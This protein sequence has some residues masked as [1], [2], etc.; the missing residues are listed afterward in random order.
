MI[1]FDLETTNHSFGSALDKRNRIVMVSWSESGGPI[2][3]YTGDIMEASEFWRALARNPN[4]CAFNA[5]FE[6]HWLKRCGYDVDA[7]RWHDP[8]LAEKVLLGNIKLP[9]NLGDTCERYNLDTKDTMIDSMMKSGVCPSDM[10]QKRLASRCNRDVRT[11]RNLLRLQMG[12]LQAN[13][14][15]HLYRNRCDFSVVLTHIEA[16][17]M[18]LS[19]ERVNDH[20]V[21]YAHQCALL[22]KQ[23]DELTGGLNMNSPKQKAEYIYDTLKFKER[24][25][26]NR[27][28]LRTAKG[29]RKTDAD[30]LTWL[31]SQAR[32]EAQKLFV[33][34]SKEYSKANA[35]LTKNLQFFRSVC[36]ELGGTFHGQFNQVIAA[37]H[38]L[39]S[40]GMP[41]KFAAYEK[42]KSVQFQNMP[43]EFKACFDAPAGYVV[44]EVDAMQLEFRV[45]AYVG[46]D[47][48]ALA[49]IA[50]P[51]F[52]AHCRS[53]AIMNDI[54]YDSFLRAYRGEQ[55]EITQATAKRLRQQAKADT[56]KPLYGG[57]RGTPAQEKY[58]KAFADRYAGIA[59]AQANWLAEVMATGELTTPWLMKF[60][61]D[62]YTNSRGLAMNKKTHKPVGPQVA[63]YPVQNLATAEIV[64]IAIVALYKRCKEL[65]LDVKF[66]NTVHDSIIAYIRDDM[67]TIKLFRRAAE[68]AFTASVYDHLQLFYGIEFNVPLGVEMIYGKFWNEGTESKYDDVLNWREAA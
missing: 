36:N 14:Q 19:A 52:D 55:N 64:P 39:T 54:P 45:A 31:H 30:T 51:N 11:T 49:D 67:R 62:V 59:A 63:N 9:M 24:M 57:T 43:R 7:H 12:K 34:L 50:D 28:P 15:I 22:S 58:Y 41:I 5:K 48:Q 23:L 26:A 32:T 4:A 44:A 6:M 18:Q 10:P 3:N 1:Y 42:S 29:G 21:K 66:V 61:W 2:H 40:S 47:K 8:M 37:T 35:A 25:G 65:K 33:M 53:A 46:Q 56:F 13:D 17:G 60:K 20:Y 16:N 68:Q 27:K 38:R